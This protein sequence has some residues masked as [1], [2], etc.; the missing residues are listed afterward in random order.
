MSEVGT[1][2]DFLKANPFVTMEEYMW[3]M[4][5]CLIKLM[6]IDNTRIEYRSN[7]KVTLVDGTNLNSLVNDLGTPIIN[8]YDNKEE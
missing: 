6:S 8:N 3:K 7:K 5:P 4:N 2:V 1:M